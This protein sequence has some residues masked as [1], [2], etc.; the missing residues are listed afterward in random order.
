MMLK[1]HLAVSTALMLFFLPSVSSKL[2]FIPVILIATL[3][4]DIDCAYS[5]LG[6]HWI[7][8]PLQFLT[9]HRGIVHSLTICIV[10]SLIFAFY[11]PVIA[12]PFFLGYASHLFVDSFTEEG[13]RVFWPLSDSV[14]GKV[15][16]GGAIEEGIFYATLLANVVLLIALFI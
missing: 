8:K 16:T 10:I 12:L 2:I 13:I 1:T 5:T 7:F 15:R 14:T 3:L 11:I 6:H 4:P 9:K